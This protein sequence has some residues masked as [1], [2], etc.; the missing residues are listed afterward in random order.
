MSRSATRALD[1]LELFGRVRR[2]LRAVEISHALGMHSSTTNQLLKTMV[3]SAHL[4]FSARDK[5]YLPSSRLAEFAGWVVDTYGAGGRVRE[6]IVALQA[7]TGM[8][9]TL[10]TPND[11]FMQVVDLVTPKG[12]GAERGLQ[13]SIFG[14]AVGSAYLATLEDA[15]V[16]RLA[17]RGRIAASQVTAILDEVAGIRSAGHADGAIE[18]SPYWSVATAL[19]MHGVQVPT[20][21]GLAG[22][23]EE[24]R[25]RVMELREVMREEIT[26]WTAQPTHDQ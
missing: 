13:V 19:P 3:G 24:V 9:V 22:P 8:V 21:L 14:S 4:V 11:L 17:H 15:E 7:R 20:V 10:S 12:H 25:P 5:S 16:R 23:A 6:L 18:G 2:P 26:R 1:V